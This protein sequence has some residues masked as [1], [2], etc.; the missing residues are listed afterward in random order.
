M[1]SIDEVVNKYADSDEVNLKFRLRP[2]TAIRAAYST[3]NGGKYKKGAQFY[4]DTNIGV[5]W[6]VHVAV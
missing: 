1:Q 5:S 6:T 3:T 4:A 2:I